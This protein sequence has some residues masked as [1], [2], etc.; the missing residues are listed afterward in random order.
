MDH[1]EVVTSLQNK[2]ESNSALIHHM[3]H[4]HRDDHVNKDALDKNKHDSDALEVSDKYDSSDIDSS[5][6]SI[7]NKNCKTKTQVCEHFG[8]DHMEN[9]NNKKEQQVSKILTPEA[10]KS[11]IE[12]CNEE[13]TWTSDMWINYWIGLKHSSSKLSAMTVTANSKICV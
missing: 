7:C 10:K 8:K 9:I 12:N 13:I 1:P 4:H 11:I 5:I 3:K 2:F 6:C